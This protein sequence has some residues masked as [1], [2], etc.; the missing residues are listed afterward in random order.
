VQADRLVYRVVD[1][2]SITDLFGNVL[3]DR[4]TITV[5][6]DTARYF[7]DR[8]VI[9][10]WSDVRMRQNEA[11]LTCRR[12]VY[13]REAEAADFSGSVRVEEGDVIGTSV[14]GE[15]RLGG[16]LLRLIED[17]RLV[18]PD[19]T[20]W[21]DTIVRD[22]TTA[23]GEATGRVKI[24][25]PGAKT[26]VT[27][28]HAVF[29]AAGDSARVD[30][31]PVLTTREQGQDKFEGRS[32][33]M[34]FFRQ[35][36]RVVMIDSVRI[37]Q[38]RTEA[39]ADTALVF[40]RERLVLKGDPQVWTGEQSTMSGREIE[41]RYR[42]KELRRIIVRGD[43][44]MEDESPDSLA[45]LYPGL[46]SLDIL[47]GDTIT[48][49]LAEGKVQ[50]STVVGNAHSLYVP[51]D[52]EDEV[53]Y[54]DVR[55][56]TINL[57][58][59]EEKVNR[60]HVEGNMSGT[61]T[62]ARLAKLAPLNGRP[63]AAPDSAGIDSLALSEPDSAGI[64]SLA[65]SAPDSLA[66]AA[67]DSAATDSL[68]L[69]SP[70]VV[71]SL[72]VAVSD[73][74]PPARYDF[75]RGA[76]TVEYSGGSV[77]FRLARRTIEIERNA[78]LT[79]GTMT[80]TAHDVSFDTEERELYATGD[81]VLVDSDQAIAGQDMGYNFDARTGAVRNGMTSFEKSYYGGQDIKRFAD[82]SL[83]IKSGR[84]TSCDLERPHYHFWSHKM[85]I[86]LQDK[87]A[88]RPVVLKIGEV[89][90]FAL[91]FY[92]KS[93]KTGRRSGILFPHFNFG[94]SRRDGRYIRDLGYF[95]ATNDYTDFMIQG[96]FN[97]R[98]DF[99]FR[100]TNRYVKRY[101][102]NGSVQYTRR[103]SLGDGPRKREWQLRWNHAQETLFDYYSLRANVQ[104]AS[105]TLE[106]N[107]L[108]R[109]LS[110][111]VVSGQ[112]RS[113]L[114]LS[115]SW[116]FMNST[117]SLSRDERVNAADDDVSTDKF[118]RS[119]VAPQ[120]SLGFRRTQLLSPLPAGRDGSLLGDLLRNTYLNHS[121]SFSSTQQ[122][123]EM[124]KSTN[125]K[126]SGNMSLDIRPPRLWIFNLSTGVSSSYRWDRTTLTGQ[127]YAGVDTVEVAPDS[128][129]FYDA[130]DPVHEVEENRVPALSINTG[131]GTTLYGLLPL[132]L[133][134]LRAIRHTMRL[135][136]SH[137]YRPRL[138]TKQK[139]SESY[140]FSLGNRF[141]LKYLSW[142]ERDSTAQEKKL[143]GI[144]DWGLSTSYAPRAEPDSR[145][146]NISSN[147]TI[148]PGRSRNLNFKVGNSI[149]PYKWVILTTRLTYGLN[150]SGRFDTGGEVLEVQAQRNEA[151]DRLGALADSTA[152]DSTYVA[153]GLAPEDFEP[154][155]PFADEFAGQ[156]RQRG[157]GARAQDPTAGGR[158]IPWDLSASLSYN[159]NNLRQTSS[160]RANLTFSASLTRNWDFSYRAS[161][162]FDRGTVTRQQWSLKRD[163]HCWRLEFIRILSARNPEFGFRIYLLSIPAIKVTR[164]NDD[165][166]GALGGGPG[167]GIY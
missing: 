148:K 79:Y 30:R 75:R 110:R 159:R 121:Y 105:Q 166:L 144:L 34:Y 86:K 49:E 109:N 54:N 161:F 38:G 24:V 58:F 6:S 43:A 10:L 155:D 115:R 104:M 119:Q 50:Q 124:T 136:V 132:K 156:E 55:G 122:K 29:S 167:G 137:S 135:S 70:A 125:Y 21:A 157:P 42:D 91:P 20:V 103:L 41:F 46:P 72:A 63:A 15:S 17:A 100:I 147:V 158:Y 81:P 131:V 152:A 9:E 12:A 52:L 90:L 31:N 89:P 141:D 140:S 95:W 92:Y 160:A 57:Y 69:S 118:L 106:S 123:Y 3:I 153:E 102:F 83:K 4:D 82:G 87:I 1:G 99:N 164:G 107:D 130:F 74:L 35:E 112:L 62:F 114:T 39:V 5:R 45:A 27:G 32:Q 142:S 154:D 13:W 16:D 84:M 146:G 73:S 11:V 108:S 133:G 138:G 111:D 28:D 76:E 51:T 67:P 162:D 60:V 26:L 93:L 113:N 56:D 14:Q 8:E 77:V 37:W 143:D 85:K 134:K 25:D 78:S 126:A 163:L 80:L 150:L 64:D 22:R 36:E 128:L 88:A 2:E 65:L 48:V 98:R 117:L 18:S 44:R 53:A 61:Y 33:D 7:R 47:E 151:I 94:W 120:L 40:G 145:W 96:D 149:D 66:L 19:Y 68:A 165:L 97:E 23:E 59:R 139:R 116:S 71:D 127:R 101:S 129:V